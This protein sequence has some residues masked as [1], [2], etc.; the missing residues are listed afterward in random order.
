MDKTVNKPVKLETNR[1]RE[2]A[3]DFILHTNRNIFLTGKAGTGKTTLLKEILAKTDK[4][5]IVAAPTGVA[6][7]NAGGI[8]LHSLFL[9]PLKSFVPIKDANLNGEQFCDRAQLVR[10]QKFNRDKLDLLLEMDLLIIDEISM[11]RADILDVIDYTLKRVRKNA[12]PFGGVQMLVIGDLYQLSP[13]VRNDIKHVLFQFYKSPYFFDSL[14][15]PISNAIVIELNKVY[16]QEDQDF[17]NILNTIREGQKDQGAIDMINKRYTENPEYSQT[18]TLTTHNKKANTINESELDKLDKP[19]KTLNASVIGLFPTSAYPTAQ[20]IQIKVGARVMCIRNH[21]EDLYFNGKIGT[22]TQIN[23]EMITLTDDD[24]KS[25]LIAPVEWKNIKYKVDPKTGKIIQEEVGSY[26]Q[27]PLRLAW[28]VTVHKSQGLTFDKV[29]LDLASTFASG[30]LYVALSRCRTLEGLT[31]S[32]QIKINNIII[33][34]RIKTFSNNTYP[35]ETLLTTLEADKKAY[36]EIRF[37]NNF[38][39]SKIDANLDNWGGVIESTEIENSIS[40]YHLMDVLQAKYMELDNVSR[41]FLSKLMEY[42]QIN[43]EQPGYL[44]DRINKAIIYFTDQIHAHFII[45]IIKHCAEFAV[46]AQSRT[47]L[48]EVESIERSFWNIIEKFYTLEYNG[49]RIYTDTP[50]H[51][52]PETIDKPK[53]KKQPKGQTLSVTYQMHQEGKSIEAIAKDRGLTTGTIESHF[54]QLIKK[55]R[56]SAFDFMKESKVK[57]GIII[58]REYPDLTFTELIQK[59]PFKISFGELRCIVAQKDWEDK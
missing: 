51:T 50:K 44:H 38:D 28:A 57:K 36:A 3:M 58:A 34:Q 49:V 19:I 18:I 30:Q 17:V 46:V 14:A 48:T 27:Y 13:V 5:Y 16:R 56:M 9:L 42:I 37:R 45:P 32:S 47:Y 40:C 6:A 52:R 7:I 29:T 20:E 10:H 39:L 11:V 31:L 23:E 43:E 54:A 24:K 4:N 35:Y 15:W 25:I 12:R 41:N 33:D 22:I 26:I 55:G 21:P 1:D 53:K 8:T 2:L 59:I